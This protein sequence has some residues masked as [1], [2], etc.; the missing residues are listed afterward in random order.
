[1]IRHVLSATD[2]GRAE[3]DEIFEK[4]D[5]LKALPRRN[6]PQSLAGR[7]VALLF[8]EPSTRTRMSFG[9]AAKALGATTI[10]TEAAGLFSSAAKGESLEDTVRILAGYEVDAI[11]I[12]H[13]ESGASRL[14]ARVSPVPVIN[15]GDGA[16]EHPTQA[17]LDLYTILRET[18]K[19]SDITVTLCG[20]LEHSRTVRSLCRLMVRYADGDPRL[21][22]VILC[23][24]KSI[25]LGA[26][27]R[28][29]LAAACIAFE[30]TS[31]LPRAMRPCDVFYQT[32]VQL[33]RFADDEGT[34]SPKGQ[35]A[36]RAMQQRFQVNARTV[37]FLRPEAVVLHPLPR[38][39]EI[40]PEVDANPRARYFEQAQNGLYI[41]MALL[42]RLLADG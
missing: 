35:E 22:R 27:V 12:R 9:L 6:R 17:L 26:D 30:E 13:K 24:P 15:A 29:E 18:R 4:A 42:E 16:D 37:E 3:I 1:M 11:V 39:G 20:D 19:T 2:F 32:R 5:W 21:F 40:T 34:V 8:Y 7:T 38:V 41:R 28:A 14:A 31:L 36:H 23:S 25:R 10:T 33:E